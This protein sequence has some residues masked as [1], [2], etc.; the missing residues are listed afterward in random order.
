VVLWFV[1]NLIF[2]DSAYWGVDFFMGI[3]SSKMDLSDMEF[4]ERLSRNAQSMGIDLSLNN[5]TE[6]AIQYMNYK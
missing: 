2:L 3:S 5:V 6:L 1:S 4:I